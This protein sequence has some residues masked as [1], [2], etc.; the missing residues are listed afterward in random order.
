MKYWDDVHG[1][2]LDPVKA[3][4]ARMEENQW[5]DKRRV[6]EQIP[7]YQMK[8]GAQPPIILKWIDQRKKRGRYRARL[9]AREIKRAKR[10]KDKLG[11]EDCFFSDAPN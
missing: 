11:P 3:A 1:G 4:E 6:M 10:V 9:V 7:R 8:P 5:I 2:Y